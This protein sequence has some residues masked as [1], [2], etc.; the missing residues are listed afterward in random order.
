MEFTTR[1]LLMEGS[2]WNVIG[3]LAPISQREK[4]VAI[5]RNLFAKGHPVRELGERLARQKSYDPRELWRADREA[6]PGG[7]SDSDIDLACGALEQAGFTINRAE[8]V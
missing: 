1:K 2:A 7:L 8:V 5:I 3:V 4:A 6:W